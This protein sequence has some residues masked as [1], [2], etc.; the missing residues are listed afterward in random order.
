MKKQPNDLKHEW[1][2]HLNWELIGHLAEHRKGEGT[3]ALK[4]AF[5]AVEQEEDHHL[6]YT[7]GFTRELWIKSLGLSA[8]LPPPEEVKTVQTA[9][10]A[11]RAENL[12]DDMLTDGGRA[13]GLPPFLNKTKQEKTNAI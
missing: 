2:D 10:G 9:I 1:K 4:T 13:G 5:E 8:V 12:R 7:K 3:G 6:Y 11:V